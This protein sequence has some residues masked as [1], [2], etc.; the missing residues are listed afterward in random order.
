MSLTQADID[1]V[2][3]VNESYEWIGGGILV[4]N[5]L[6]L[7]TFFS[8]SLLY[9]KFQ[10]L[11]VLSL[12]EM[13]AGIGRFMAG[14]Y[15]VVMYK[16]LPDV[17]LPTNTTVLYCLKSP[18]LPFLLLG[19]QWPATICFLIGLERFIAV[20]KPMF[21]R[22]HFTG[23][24]RITITII[25][26]ALIL[27]VMVGTYLLLYFVEADLP[28]NFNCNVDQ[29]FPVHYSDFHRLYTCFAHTIGFFL[30][31]T[32]FLFAR[33][34]SH[35]A[36]REGAEM[37]AEAKKINALLIVTGVAVILVVVPTFASWVSDRNI[38]ALPLF[39]SNYSMIT[40]NINAALNFFIYLLFNSMFRSR[41]IYLLTC[42]KY[43]LKTDNAVSTVF[44]TRENNNR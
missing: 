19:A 11:I 43:S 38:L 10:I 4:T 7:L 23:R 30:S 9:Q 25:F 21:Y 14:Y 44:P 31:V 2:I 1:N 39:L 32:A 29:V 34:K 24:L 17:P 22:A 8:T 3:F 27:F 5:L 26:L 12:A 40:F 28:A 41:F 20:H 42:S 15:R 16:D 37:K 36:G 6:V 18:W 33:K 35:Q 13:I